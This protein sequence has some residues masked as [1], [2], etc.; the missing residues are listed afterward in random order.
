[1][2]KYVPTGGRPKGSTSKPPD[3][4]A[5]PHAK[6]EAER[7]ERL[8][9]CAERKAVKVRARNLAKRVAKEA[10]GIS[11]DRE[12][13]IARRSAGNKR[14]WQEKR[15]PREA[16]AKARLAAKLAP[17]MPVLPR[18]KGNRPAHNRPALM[19]REL[20]IVRRRR[21]GETMTSIA[22]ALGCKFQSI[23]RSIKLYQQRTGETV[24][25]PPRVKSR[26]G[27]LFTKRT[28]GLPQSHELA[29]QPAHAI[30]E[31][32]SIAGIVPLDEM[33]R[34]IARN[35]HDPAREAIVLDACKAAA[36]Y[37][38]ARLAPIEHTGKL[39]L[40][41][42]IERLTKEQLA[43]FAATLRASLAADED[44]GG[45]EGAGALDAAARTTGTRLQ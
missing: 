36:P 41:Q 35:R 42:V 43:E 12:A 13:V 40:E 37:I 33:L 18:T 23:S 3:P 5:R 20:E 38:H 22:A 7:Q 16:A 11:F 8:R 27:Q 4:R 26:P 39:S 30:A 10:A 29:A 1:M 19:V 25:P 28:Q 17:G 14:A 45:A 44:R 21:A 15:G 9:Q 32:I 34:I 2:S 31:A 24:L 6:T